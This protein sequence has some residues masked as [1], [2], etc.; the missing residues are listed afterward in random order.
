MAYKMGY[1][2]TKYRTPE[3]LK[4]VIPFSSRK[5]RMSCVYKLNQT[6]YRIFVKGAPDWLH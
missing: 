6:T 1:E 2:Y 3:N 5:K 4:R